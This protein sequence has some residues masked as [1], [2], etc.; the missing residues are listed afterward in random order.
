DTT[1][2]TVTLDSGDAL[3]GR[4]IILATG[5]TWRHLAIEDFERLVGKGI[6]YGAAR[7][8]APNTHGLDVHIV[9]AGNSAGQAAMFFANHARTV[10]ILCRADTLEKS[11]S[12]YLIEQ[13][14]TREN[15]RVSVRSEV[16]AVHGD[17]SLEAIDVFDSATETTARRE[18]GGL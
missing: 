14:A 17:V 1:A 4:T 10:T 11:M 15:I 13:L 2:R 18:S 9:G 3:R 5:V 8:E 6:Y 7:S 16:A 12:H